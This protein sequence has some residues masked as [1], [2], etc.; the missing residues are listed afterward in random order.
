MKVATGMP[1]D[2]SGW[3]PAFGVYSAQVYAPVER[4]FVSWQQM[5]T[6][7]DAAEMSLPVHIKN[8]D[9]DD[10][11]YYYYCCCWYVIMQSWCDAAGRDGLYELL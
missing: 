2:E 7:T 9:D 10:G 8:D 1:Q 5:V 3:T 4:R 6:G 11:C